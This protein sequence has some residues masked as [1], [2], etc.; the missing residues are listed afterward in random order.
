MDKMT[1]SSR[2]KLKKINKKMDT[3]ENKQKI[4]TSIEGLLDKIKAIIGTH[5]ESGKKASEACKQALQNAD[6]RQSAIIQEI[7]KNINLMA[8]TKSLEEGNC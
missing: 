5:K 2:E 8:N 1:K 7:M 6:V 4:M 3:Q